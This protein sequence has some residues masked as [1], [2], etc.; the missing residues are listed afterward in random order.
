MKA[1]TIKA[2]LTKKHNELLESI[3]DENVRKLVKENSVIS[4]GCIVS[5]LLNEQV[6][7]YDY[8]FTNLET[9][10]AVAKYY[11]QKFQELNTDKS[12]GATV[13]VADGRVRIAVQSAGITSESD[14]GTK[15]YQYFETLPDPTKAGEYLDEV[16]DVVAEDETKPKYRPIFL[17]DN[18]I[19]LSNSIQI[20]IR[21]Y[22]SPT[23]IHDNYDYIHATSYWLSNDGS[24]VLPQRA[25]EAI[26]TK[27]LI[28]HGSKYPLASI[29]RSRKFIKRGWSINAG[30]YLKMV[31]QLSELD[32]K[33]PNV[34]KEQLIGMDAAYFYQVLDMISDK[35]KEDADFK[36]TSTYLIEVIDRL[37]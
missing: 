26:I 34:L 15:A 13:F 36:L 37:F 35:M 2:I 7:D 16:M 25:L 11:L 24:L 33:N 22:G 23:E 30:Q 9:T 14:Q 21:F 12:V 8:Y 32:L 20:V 19:T 31:L 1:K 5:M 28:Y 3:T 27:E 4:G 6:N 18:A 17:T 10:E 29:I